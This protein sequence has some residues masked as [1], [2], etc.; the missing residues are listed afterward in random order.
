MSLFK[1]K[2]SFQERFDESGRVLIKFPN[3]IPIVVEKDPRSK[4]REIDRHKY[5]VSDTLTMSQFLYTIRKRLKLEPE[6][7]VMLFINNFIPAQEQFISHY[8]NNY[9]DK[10]NFLYIVYSVDNTFG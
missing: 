3:K 6:E 9:K 8:Y 2:Y 7:N 10:D 5:L 4:V 1:K